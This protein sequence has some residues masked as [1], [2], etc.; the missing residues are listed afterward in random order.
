[1]SRQTRVVLADDRMAVREALCMLIEE[2]TR[3]GVAT[4]TRPGGCSLGSAKTACHF[5]TQGGV[6]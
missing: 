2:L 1:M 4:E 3:A 6:H 5:A